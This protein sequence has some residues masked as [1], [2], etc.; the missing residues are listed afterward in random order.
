MRTIGRWSLVALMANSILGAGIFGLPSL[1]AA[2]LGGYGPLS[3]IIAGCGA[4]II[5]CGGSAKGHRLYGST[6]GASLSCR[7]LWSCATRHN[8]LPACASFT[9]SIERRISKPAAQPPRFATERDANS[10]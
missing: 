10:R 4:L 2:R 5:L 6:V 9:L 3:C 7:L 8:L 1:I